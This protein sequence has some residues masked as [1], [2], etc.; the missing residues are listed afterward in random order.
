[1]RHGDDR[2]I[3]QKTEQMI[4]SVITAEK[5]EVRLKDRR[6]RGKGEIESKGTWGGNSDEGHKARK[7]RKQR[8]T[9]EMKRRLGSRKKRERK[10]RVSGYGREQEGDTI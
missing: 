8:E 6:L 7:N 4:P 10:K 2:L 5:A 3:T 9:V 1:M